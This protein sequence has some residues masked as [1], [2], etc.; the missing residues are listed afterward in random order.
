[1]AQV[2][3]IKIIIIMLLSMSVSGSPLVTQ[4]GGAGGAG[5]VGQGYFTKLLGLGLVYLWF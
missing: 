1:M 5:G 2:L 3:I 4:N